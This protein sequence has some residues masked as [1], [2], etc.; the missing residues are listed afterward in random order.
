MVPD[1]LKDVVA[2]N[3]VETVRI[4]EQKALPLAILGEVVAEESRME[5]YR[6]HDF[7]SKGRH[8]RPEVPI[9]VVQVSRVESRHSDDRS[10]GIFFKLIVSIYLDE[11]F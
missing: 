4:L 11:F 5:K 6:V 9:L 7:V 3:F 2:P 1:L 8:M 10:A